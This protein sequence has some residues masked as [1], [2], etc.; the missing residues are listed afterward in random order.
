MRNYR[1][2]QNLR[3]LT[4]YQSEKS[5]TSIIKKSAFTNIQDKDGKNYYIHPYIEGFNTFNKKI[6][7]FLVNE[8]VPGFGFYIL[9]IYDGIGFPKKFINESKNYSGDFL[10]LSKYKKYEI[11][12]GFIPSHNYD[13]F[14]GENITNEIITNSDFSPLFSQCIE[15]PS[16]KIDPHRLLL[17]MNPQN[18]GVTK[19][20]SDRFF[21]NNLVGGHYNLSGLIQWN[22]IKNINSEGIEKSK[23]EEF[24]KNS[25]G[26][27]PTTINDYSD[28]TLTL[29]IFQGKS[30]SNFSNSSGYIQLYKIYPIN[31][32]SFVKTSEY[33]PGYN[34]SCI[35]N[36]KYNS[37]NMELNK[38]YFTPLINY[39][40]STMY[41]TNIQ[42]ENLYD[43]DN[44]LIGYKINTKLYD[45]Q[46]FDLLKN[47][48]IIGGNTI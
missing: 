43:N 1:K 19:M 29:P 25:V 30:V 14:I 7:Y 40:G 36:D 37:L 33:Q 44:N 46:E 17:I 3:T 27:C 12:C 8:N 9:N 10:V 39:S 20:I 35:F 41:N 4:H 5:G 2:G 32:N 31:S 45:F 24:I 6:S 22:T 42:E 23:G 15:I 48:E 38:W 28:D 47:I 21:I 34:E 13:D 26:K 11:T 16:R 18:E